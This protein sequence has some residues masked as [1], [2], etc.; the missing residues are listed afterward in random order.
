MSVLWGKKD[1]GLLDV[2]ENAQVLLFY[3][4]KEIIAPTQIVHRGKW[5]YISE[6]IQFSSKPLRLH[7]MQLFINKEKSIFFIS[8]FIIEFL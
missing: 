4:D 2:I 3:G 5:S 6:T 8:L 1:V 7:V